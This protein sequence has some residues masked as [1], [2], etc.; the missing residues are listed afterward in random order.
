MLFFKVSILSMIPFMEVLAYDQ[1]GCC[2][3]AEVRMVSSGP[4][5][6]DRQLPENPFLWQGWFL[7][8]S[9]LVRFVDF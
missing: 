2:A 4:L 6:T 3:N 1:R 9:L 5:P 7:V 8:L